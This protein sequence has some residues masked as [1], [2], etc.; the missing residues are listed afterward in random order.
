MDYPGIN[1]FLGTRASLM[2]DVVFVAMFA[3]LPVLGWSILQ[4][5]RGRYL[6]H[7]RV[8]L[9]LGSILLVTVAL[10]E[11]DMRLNDWTVR[12]AASPYYVDRDGERQLV[13]PL[14]LCRADRR[15]VGLGDRP[16]T[17]TISRAAATGRAQSS[18]HLLGPSGRYRDADDG[19][20]RL[21]LLLAG[22]Y[23]DLRASQTNHV[24]LN[25][26]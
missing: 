21:D 1:G 5:R 23:R 2:L 7:K 10:F 18:T 3:V 24:P 4:V 26:V 16:G 13:D 22:V 17:A 20:D 19:G 11:I 25:I 12:A 8:Q 9:T 6:L 14:V 15:V